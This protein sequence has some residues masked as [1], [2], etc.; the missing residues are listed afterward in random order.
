MKRLS[1][2]IHFVHSQNET[3]TNA[4]QEEYCDKNSQPLHDPLNTTPWGGIVKYMNNY[5]N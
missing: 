2:Y 5:K 4:F 3:K 1:E